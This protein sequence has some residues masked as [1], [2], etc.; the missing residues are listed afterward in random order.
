MSFVTIYKVT[1]VLIFFFFLLLKN[2]I[3]EVLTH[4]AL[5]VEVP[6][7]PYE[8]DTEGGH[9]RLKHDGQLSKLRGCQIIELPL[10][11]ILSVLP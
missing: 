1:H 6:P 4:L 11:I 2:C 3:S 10:P 8:F 5:T 9:T 7:C